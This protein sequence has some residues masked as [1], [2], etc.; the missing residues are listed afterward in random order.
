MMT[1][2]ERA[3][4]AALKIA[5]AVTAA[6]PAAA[7]AAAAAATPQQQQQQRAPAAAAAAAAPDAAVLA[8]A[9]AWKEHTA[10]DGR[11]YYHNRLTK[12][13]R[14]T[15]PEEMKAAQAAAR[16]PQAAP[17]AADG[18]AGRSPLQP[19]PGAA[20]AA[21]AGSPV[22]AA[23]AQQPRPTPVYATKEEARDAFKELLAEAGIG[24]ED[25]WDGALRRLVSDPR[26][27]A[28]KAIGER[29]T[30]FNEYVQVGVTQGGYRWRLQTAVTDGGWGWRLPAES[31]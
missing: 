20:P 4:A 12:E 23:A 21:A 24:G 15:M 26:Y 31:E 30:V 28:I 18:P 6:A 13:S 7:A 22:A 17:L 5:Q 8:A 11:K 16:A 27:G 2:E 29:K 10:P 9:A 1:P 3:R 19:S 14:W 25:T